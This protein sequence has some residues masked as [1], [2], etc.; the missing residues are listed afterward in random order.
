MRRVVRHLENVLV[1][2]FLRRWQQSDSY[3]DE[4]QR[5]SSLLLVPKQ[6]QP[7]PMANNAG[8]FHAWEI[9][10]CVLCV[11]ARGACMRGRRSKLCRICRN[12]MRS[13]NVAAG[14]VR[15]VSC[16]TRL[17]RGVSCTALLR[18]VAPCHCSASSGVPLAPLLCFSPDDR[19]RAQGRRPAEQGRS[20]L[21]PP[22]LCS[23]VEP[24]IHKN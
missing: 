12:T 5:G 7:A 22:A 20:A 11:R 16:C 9:V 13:D 24:L 4:Y 17:R 6:P 10:V 15:A 18:C 2:A 8:S 3:E 19:G 21:S 23:A 14:D 1:T